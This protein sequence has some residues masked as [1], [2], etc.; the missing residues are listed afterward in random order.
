MIPAGI[1]SFVGC[2]TFSGS[3]SAPWPANVRPA[4]SSNNPP[5]VRGIEIDHPSEAALHALRSVLR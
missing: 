3:Q 5:K 2:V 4:R 1:L